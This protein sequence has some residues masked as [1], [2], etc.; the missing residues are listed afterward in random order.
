MSIFSSTVALGVTPEQINSKVG[1]FGVPEFG[2][3]FVRGMLLDTMPK[4]FMDLICISGLS[5][6]TDVWL[7]NAKELI[8]AEIVTSISEAV[9]TR[10][11]IMVYLIK[12]GLPPNSAF[13]I[14]EL[15]RKGKALKDPKWPEY[16][17][18]MREHNVPEWYIDSCRKIK[19]MFPK[20]HAA[21]YVMMAFRIAWFKVHIPLAYY[22]AYFSIR[23]KAFDAEFMIHGKEKVKEKLKEI[24]ALG[25]QAA[26]KDK[27]MYDDLEIVLEMYER[28]FKFLQIDLYKS[29]ASKFQIEDGMLRPPFNSISGMGNVA[30]EG[31]YKA[32]N[33][34]PFSSI[35][36]LRK[37]AK[38]V[39]QQLNC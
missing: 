18:L 38:L 2:T 28:G 19:Y 5:H 9:C 1:T 10:D 24:D 17:E 35:E 4:K 33:E 6:G 36:D 11:D 15:V 39:M 23:A 12:M 14:M 27:D 8:D 3:R 30:A 31:I 16:E 13:K 37:R 29:H 22:A 7:G 34:E 21:A 25:N 32:A 20:A 26:P